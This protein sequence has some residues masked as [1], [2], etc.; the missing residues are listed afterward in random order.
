[1]TA[2]YALQRLVPEWETG[3]NGDALNAAVD[4]DWFSTAGY[5]HATIEVEI[6]DANGSVTSIDLVYDTNAAENST[7]VAHRGV[8]GA[9]S[10]GVETLTRHI[11]R[12]DP[13]SIGKNISY[14]LP[15]NCAAMRL[16]VPSAATGAAAS[17]TIVVRVRLG[18][19]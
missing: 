6:T 12:W 11:L 13:S 17:D 9:I 18:V 15:L 5:N 2:R 19:I 14:P 10:G 3:I 7:S 8:A 4:G 1:M 16:S